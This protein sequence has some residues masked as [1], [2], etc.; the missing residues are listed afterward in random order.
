MSPSFK[1]IVLLFI[2]AIV[3][4]TTAFRVAPRFSTRTVRAPTGLSMMWDTKRVPTP[5]VSTS[6]EE[7]TLPTTAP[8]IAEDGSILNYFGRRS[9]PGAGLDERSPAGLTEELLEAEAASLSRMD[10][11][12]RMHSLKMTLEGDFIGTAA[13]MQR[14]HNAATLEGTLPASLVSST[15]TAPH[16]AAG[17]LFKDWDAAAF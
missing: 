2:L 17:G 7:T 15:A 13:K 9:P 10:R 4:T 16:M 5:Q 3:S 14:I 11:S 1:N 6:V 12:F 8:R